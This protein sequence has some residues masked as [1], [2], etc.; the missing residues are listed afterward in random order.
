MPLLKPA[1]PSQDRLEVAEALADLY[2]ILGGSRDYNRLVEEHLDLV[3]DK[4]VSDGWF[5]EDLTV[6]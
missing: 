3:K 5:D 4:L 2:R 6:R 1:F